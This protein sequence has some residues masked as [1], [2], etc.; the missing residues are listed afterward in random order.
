MGPKTKPFLYYLREISTLLHSLTY[1]S[2]TLNFMPMKVYKEEEE[3][4]KEEKEEEEEEEKKKAKEEEEE[5]EDGGGG[6]GGGRKERKVGW[7][8]ESYTIKSKYTSKM[9]RPVQEMKSVRN[10][11]IGVQLYGKVPLYVIPCFQKH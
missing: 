8:G 1:K 3:E 9:Y 11:D 7:K 2:V 6:G 4:N 10:D 5:E